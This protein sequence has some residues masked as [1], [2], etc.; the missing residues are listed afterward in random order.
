LIDVLI[1]DGKVVA[2][3]VPMFAE[4]QA[5]EVALRQVTN[6]QNVTEDYSHT[7]LT[8]RKNA[9]AFRATISRHATSSPAYWG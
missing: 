4:Q 5:P 9:V 7:G 2:P 6:G 1:A 3:S 8:L